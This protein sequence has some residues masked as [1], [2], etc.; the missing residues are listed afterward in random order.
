MNESW[1]CCEIGYC[2]GEAY[3]N[4][5]LMT[6]ACGAVLD[7]LFGEAG[8]NR[9]SALHAVPNVGSGKVM[10]KCGMTCEGILRQYCKTPEGEYVRSGGYSILREEWLN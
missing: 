1:A 9:I 7:Y 4:R 2:L 6:E 10:K 5:G 3:W 8:F